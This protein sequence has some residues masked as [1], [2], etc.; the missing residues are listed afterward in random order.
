MQTLVNNKKRV[1]SSTRFFNVNIK[2]GKRFG[3][4]N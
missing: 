3:A 2:G 4:S 1:L